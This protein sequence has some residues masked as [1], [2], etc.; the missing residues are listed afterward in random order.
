MRSWSPKTEWS[1]AMV[2]APSYLFQACDVTYANRADQMTRWNI[3]NFLRERGAARPRSAGRRPLEGDRAIFGT[4][5]LCKDCVTRF[6]TGSYFF[7]EARHVNLLF[8]W[9]FPFQKTGNGWKGRIPSCS[10]AHFRRPPG[11]RRDPLRGG[12]FKQRDRSSSYG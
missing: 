6:E 7:K 5:R 2:K 3:F 12:I 1:W 10:A 11:P 8:I 4:S 9:R